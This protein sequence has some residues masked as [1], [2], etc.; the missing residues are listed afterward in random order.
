MMRLP[1]FLAVL[2]TLLQVVPAMASAQENKQQEVVEIPWGIDQQTL[3]ST[4]NR[5][6]FDQDTSVVLHVTN[7]N[8]VHYTVQYGVEETVLESYALLD[9][10]WKD[11]FRLGGADPLV[12]GDCPGP[13]DF[14]SS[15]RP[16]EKTIRHGRSEPHSF[17]V[18]F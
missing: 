15:S 1:H 14:R 7:F 3:Q 5:K 8:F 10:L 2:A 12:R 17:S 6:G 16:V 4:F 13:Y 9:T 18:D 11:V